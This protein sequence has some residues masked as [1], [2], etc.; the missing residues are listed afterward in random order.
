[1]TND[2]PIYAAAKP[3]GP[4]IDVLS[5]VLEPTYAVYDD[6]ILWPAIRA[7]VALKHGKSHPVK[8]WYNQCKDEGVPV[9]IL[10]VVDGVIAFLLHET[11]KT[12]KL[13]EP[14][15]KRSVHQEVRRI[16]NPRPDGRFARPRKRQRAR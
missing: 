16:L 6:P 7:E 4:N 11:K 12:T 5:R 2:P 9:N 10:V 14:N 15:L 3:Y 8:A 1:M 13:D